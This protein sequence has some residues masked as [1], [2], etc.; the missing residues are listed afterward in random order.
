MGAYDDRLPSPFRKEKKGMAGSK[1]VFKVSDQWTISNPIVTSHHG[2]SPLRWPFSKT[3]HR[4][5]YRYYVRR[6]RVRFARSWRGPSNHIRYEACTLSNL[7]QVTTVT[8]E[9]DRYPNTPE[10]GSGK[11]PSILYYDHAGSFCGVENGVD[12]QDEDEFLRV[13]WWET[14]IWSPL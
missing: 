11:V 8:N 2:I 12:F 7:Y 6:R 10:T 13:R 5:R 4:S 1:E 3:R 14:A 9:R